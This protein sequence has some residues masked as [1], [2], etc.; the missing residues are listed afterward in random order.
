MG[1]VPLSE[2]LSAAPPGKPGSAILAL[3]FR[4]FYLLAAAF[5]SLVLPLWLAIFAGTLAPPPAFAAV[6]WHAHEMLF[7]FACAVI[8]GFLFTAGRA[9]T[10]MAT[11]TGLPLALLALL[12]LAGRLT[13]ALAPAWLA[14]PIDL[15]FLPS[16]AVALGRVL[17]RAGNKRNYFV[18]VLLTALAGSNLLFHLRATGIVGGNPLQGVFIGLALVTILETVISGRIIPAFTSNGLGGLK[19]DRNQPLEKAAVALTI[20]ALLSWALSAPAWLVVPAAT[21]AGAL[22]FVRS[23]SWHPGAT[24]KTPLLWILHISHGWLVPGLLLIAATGL[25]WTAPSVAVHALAIGAMAG[26]IMGMITRTALGHTGRTLIAG[27]IE[28]TCYVLIHLAVLTRVLPTL[29]V[30]TLYWPGLLLAGAAWS[31]A[32]LLYL[33]RYGPILWRPRIDGRPG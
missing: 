1:I 30:P 32:F 8:A 33:V 18:L 12:W 28:T 21:L 3:G 4:P 2:P 29:L 16:V 20:V 31:S 6:A 5:A 17:I 23:L 13:F 10:G 25:G 14:A 24:L 15:A 27:R 7:G 9:W 22:Q 19:I 26:L 11:P